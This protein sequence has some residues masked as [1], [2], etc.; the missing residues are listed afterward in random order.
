MMPRAPVLA[1]LRESGELE[2]DADIILF[3]HRQYREEETTCT[4]AKNR[5]GR[6]TDIPLLFRPEFVAFDAVGDEER[7]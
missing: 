4:V 2:H 3:L 6:L 7:A 1:D 5:D